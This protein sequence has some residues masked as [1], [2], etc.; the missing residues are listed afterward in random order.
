LTV[1][2]VAERLRVCRATVY[3][4]VAEGP[5]PTVRILVRSHPCPLERLATSSVSIRAVSYEGAA[6]AGLI[7][8]YSSHRAMTPRNVDGVRPRAARRHRR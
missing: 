4:L 2:E 1:P 3:R 5:I 8:G 7:T 6:S